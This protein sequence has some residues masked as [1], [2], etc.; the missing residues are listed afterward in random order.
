MWYIL[1]YHSY[2]L[3]NQINIELHVERL[4]S[5]MISQHDVR[6]ENYGNVIFI[7]NMVF[8]IRVTVRLRDCCSMT[9]R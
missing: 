3:Q 9:A 5:F 6:I 2:V 8:L 1:A 4:Y 7:A